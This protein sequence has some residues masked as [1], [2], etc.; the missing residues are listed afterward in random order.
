MCASLVRPLLEYGSAVWDPYLQ[1]D[2]WNIEMVQRHAAR[3]VESNDG[4]NSSV[5]SILSSMQWPTLQHRQYITRLKLLYNMIHDASAINIPA[6]LTTT[7]Y[8][9]CCHH[10]LRYE[11]PFAKSNHYKFSYFPKSINDWNHFSIET[12]ESPSLQLFIDRLL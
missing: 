7:N 10:P 1:K 8:P 11:T 9:T 4:Y 6:Y 5:S 2:I 3:W 12:I